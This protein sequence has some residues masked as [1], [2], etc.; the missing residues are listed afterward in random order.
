MY[1]ALDLTDTQ[2]PYS[3][4]EKLDVLNEEGE[5]GDITTMDLKDAEETQPEN[6][7]IEQVMSMDTSKNM[8]KPTTSITYSYDDDEN[9]Y[10]AQ[11]I[12]P[13]TSTPL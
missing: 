8:I 3:L 13:L 1:I 2:L 12:E 11:V 9:L 5:E 10:S 4:E 6:R 7:E